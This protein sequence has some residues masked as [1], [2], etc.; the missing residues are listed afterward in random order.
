[1][2][3]A[4][5]KV[6]VTAQQV[7][8]RVKPYIPDPLIKMFH[9][10]PR[11]GGVTN[12]FTIP[13]GFGFSTSALMAQTQ[14][15][16][17]GV[18]VPGLAL[19]VIGIVMA[20]VYVFAYCC[21]CCRCCRVQRCKRDPE[22][23]FKGM[24]RFVGPAL[25]MG[26]LAFVNLAL[27]ISVIVYTPNFGAGI[28]AVGVANNDIV[29]LLGG[30]AKLLVGDATSPATGIYSYTKVNGEPVNVMPVCVQAASRRPCTSRS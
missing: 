11:Y 27:V 17:G 22:V 4:T 21:G 10:L 25:A 15:Y 30:A 12:N 8:T 16:L 23:Y 13:S 2:V 5:A 3:V 28:T 29:L 26:I 18:V 1:V 14:T 6:A 19:I 20:V 24:R 9:E 7:I